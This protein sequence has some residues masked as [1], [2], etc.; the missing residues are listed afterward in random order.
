MTGAMTGSELEGLSIVESDH[1][2]DSD[3]NPAARQYDKKIQQRIAEAA[4]F[5]KDRKIKNTLA[6]SSY[7]PDKSMDSR[8]SNQHRLNSINKNA[9]NVKD[10]FCGATRG[11]DMSSNEYLSDIA[12][13]YGDESNFSKCYRKTQKSVRK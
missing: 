13:G 11:I 5:T 7:K 10:V 12:P 6:N 2:Y 3:D 9:G 4:K 1:L 8:K